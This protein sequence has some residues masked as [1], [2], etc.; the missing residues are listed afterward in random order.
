[1]PPW[2]PEPGFGDFAGERRLSDAEVE[3]IR[4]WADSGSAE[5][6]P[7]SKP[8]LPMWRDGWELGQPD[9]VLRLP[10]PY[11]LPA[12]GSDVFRNFVVSVP[13]DATRYV[14]AVEFH[15]DNPRVLHHAS[16]GIDRTRTSRQL[17]QA[18]PAPGFALMPE[19]DVPS[20]FGWSPGKGP[21]VEPAGLAWPLDKHSD[22][23]LQLHL[24]PDRMPAT[25]QPS[26]GLFFSDTPPTRAAVAVKLE[27]KTIDIAPGQ[28]DYAIEDTYLLPVAVEALSIYPHAHY[29]ARTIKTFATL[30]DGSVRWLIS[31]KD[32]NFRWQDE[33]RYAA[34][35]P[36]PAGTKLT[37]QITYDNSADNPRNPSRP[38]THVIWGPRSTD[39]MGAVWLKVTPVRAADAASLT[40]D[41]ASRAFQADL[42][43]AELR[44]QLQPGDAVVH[45]VLGT[46]YLQA[47][48]L[49]DAA[50]QFREALRLE[51][52]EAEAHSNL[53]SA[54]Q[55]QGRTNEAM[56]HLR[57]AIRLAPG[58]D[59]A[60][61]NLANALRASGHADEALR[62]YAAA[63]RINPQ[64]A[65]AHVNAALVLGER[66][67]IDEATR[68]L[69]DAIDIDPRH[70]EAHRNLAVALALQG[71]T[72]QAIDELRSALAIQPDLLEAK[73]MLDLLLSRTG[74]VRR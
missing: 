27:S 64:N 34:P 50:T 32:W 9:L 2:P 33:Y 10:Q 31:I 38:P 61:F 68:H 1:M 30:P 5:G 63:L 49:A 69:R 4:R 22:L 51:P 46:R 58:S 24:L 62:E 12:G 20:V 25:T 74:A 37:M 73:K 36:L 47:G 70:A 56:P 8:P 59:R 52:D 48:R 66:Q 41:A 6:E 18:D 67:R 15:G 35:V 7:A 14:R 45:N 65:D 55:L 71:R 60:H 42:R 13:L 3:T 28:R 17:D 54:L 11:T 72:D 23:V 53:G 19:N 26:I 21:T 16:L 44:V 39:E 29:L 57:T 43:A 40:R